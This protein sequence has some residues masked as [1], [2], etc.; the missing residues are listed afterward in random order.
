MIVFETYHKLHSIGGGIFIG[1]NL[2]YGSILLSGIDLERCF[3]SV[4]KLEEIP[5][6]VTLGVLKVF[7]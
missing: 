1:L 7:R 5:S 6:T 4:V 2:L 3:L